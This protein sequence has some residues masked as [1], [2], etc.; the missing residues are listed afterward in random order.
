VRQ[1]T[2]TLF[3]VRLLPLVDHS[4]PNAGATTAGAALKLLESLPDGFVVGD[5]DGRVLMANRAFLDMV[6]L[7]TLE[8]VRGRLL[9]QWVGRP[10][11]DLGR[12]LATLREHGV[13]RLF[14]TALHGN[15]GSSSEVEVSSVSVSVAADMRVGFLIRDIGR[16]LVPSARGARD[17]GQAV[18]QLT[19]LVGRISLKTLVRDTTDL[20]E[21]HFIEAALTTTDDNRTTAAEVLGVSR[22][23]LYLKLRRYGLGADA[24]APPQKNGEHQ[25]QDSRPDVP[26]SDADQL[27]ARQG[28]AT[29]TSV[30]DTTR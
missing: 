29:D 2:S 12:L 3:L 28:N 11:A 10:G 15:L 6:E 16:R 18:E 5:A 27:T 13:V 14:G 25:G 20:V 1:D 24:D 26:P 17:L 9:S 21:R 7:P 23:S 30:T 22:Q 4:G 19:T 8:Q